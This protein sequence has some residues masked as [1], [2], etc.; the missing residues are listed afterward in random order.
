[1][2]LTFGED[3]VCRACRGTK[4]L[5]GMTCAG[6]D[7]SGIEK[8]AVQRPPVPEKVEGLREGKQ[9]RDQG[10]EKVERHEKV[11]VDRAYDWIRALFPGEIFTADDLVKAIGLPASRNAVGAAMGGA[12]RRN[13]I[14]SAGI[15]QS[16]RPDRHAGMVRRWE[17]T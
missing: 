2:S 17:R 5:R 9:R 13:L 4:L 3:R 7:G 16:S 11:W 10:E 6:C 15:D 1:M 14:R 8:S 12:S